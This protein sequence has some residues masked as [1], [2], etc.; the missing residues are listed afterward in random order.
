MKISD[1][2]I[3]ETRNK[4]STNIDRK[5]TNEI[6]Q[7]IN[8]E[9]QEVPKIINEH[10]ATIEQIVDVVVDRFQ[11]GGRLIYIGAG[12]SG[13]IG[14]LDASECPPTF[15]TDSSMMSALIAGW[16]KAV[17]KSVEGAEDNEQLGREDIIYAQV[18]AKDVVIGITASGQAP[19][20]ISGL[21]KAQELGAKTVSFTCNTN[22]AL[23]HYSDIKL[24]IEVGPEVI[25][26]STR[27]KAGTAQKLVL[28]MI[29][30]A[31]MIKIGKVYN[32][33]MVDVQPLNK[34]LNKRAIWIIQS[35]NGCT[36]ER[37]EELFRSAAG[38]PKIAI[39]MH[40]CQ[41]NNERASQLLEAGN[42]FVHRAVGIYTN[43][44]WQLSR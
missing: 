43:E 20:V 21:K 39:V 25:T 29:S 35:G 26:G 34:K 5:S 14:I 4:A 31:A 17:F 11:K 15:G 24:E 19:Y 22:T 27:M 10:L 8:R 18:G 33:L 37:A 13:R 9:D 28:N 36:E 12:T 1:K 40:L 6:L 38:N 32:N 23:E 30:T 3:T 44:K 42:G 2:L 7:I 16:K 41:V